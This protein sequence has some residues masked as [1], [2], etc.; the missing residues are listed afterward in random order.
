MTSLFAPLWHHIENCDRCS[1]VDLDLCPEADR[2]QREAIERAAR[3][4]APMPVES[5]EPAS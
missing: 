2:M 3:L 1:H 5:E 4:I